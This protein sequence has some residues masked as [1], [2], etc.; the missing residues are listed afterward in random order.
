[1]NSTLTTQPFNATAEL[2]KLRERKR[3]TRQLAYYQSRLHRYRT[4]IVALRQAGA[5]Y[6]EIALWL[7]HHKHMKSNNTG[8]LN[9][10]SLKQCALLPVKNSK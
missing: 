4:E 5:S 6:R 9:Y 3:T 1:M 7:R 10:H 8:K 2:T